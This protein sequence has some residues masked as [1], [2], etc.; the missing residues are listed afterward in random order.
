[1]Y[2]EEVALLSPKYERYAERMKKLIKEGERIASTAL[3]IIPYIGDS[4]KVHSWLASVKNIL[5]LTFGDKSTYSIDL[6]NICKLSSNVK[7]QDVFLSMKGL[8]EGALD[9]LE[10]GFLVGQE[11][12][13]AGEIFDSVLEQ[14][15]HLN[16]AGHK[17][18][19]AVLARV[20]V[21]DALRRISRKENLDDTKKA[22]DLNNEL[23]KAGRYGQPRWRRVQALLDI[24][25]AAAHGKFDEYNSDDVKTI[26]EEVERFLAEEL[27]IS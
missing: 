23:K 17:D 1:M 20:V 7:S 4:A 11:F 25:N 8:L 13:I 14:A 5:E 3:G 24:G 15:K 19:A 18:P 22:S 21:E 10:S 9:D 26:I 2:V 6:N 12:L 16:K 27:R